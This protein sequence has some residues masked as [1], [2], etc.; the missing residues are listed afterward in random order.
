MAASLNFL[1]EYINFQRDSVFYEIGSKM[2][3]QKFIFYL[4]PANYVHPP[5]GWMYYF[6]FFRRSCPMSGVRCPAS[7]MVSA[8]LKEKY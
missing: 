3:L 7:R 8:Q 5:G 1:T 4:K 2:K 6:C